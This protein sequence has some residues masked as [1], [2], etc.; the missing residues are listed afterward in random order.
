[1]PVNGYDPR[2]PALK[3]PPLVRENRLYQADW[4]M[5]FYGF[6]ASEIVDD[7]FPL[8]DLEVDPKMA[9][10]LRHPEYFP[11]DVNSAD[12]QMILRVPGIGVKSAKMIVAARRYG[13]LNLE[14]VGKMGAVLKRA[15]YFITENGGLYRNRRHITINELGAEGVRRA[16]LPSIKESADLQLKL[17][18][19]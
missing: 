18:L 6:E 2:L 7:Q 15:R 3:Q 4:L 9:W 11:V 10:A 13:K 8:L 14:Q 12:Y 19:W 16:L 5:R 17:P 1:M